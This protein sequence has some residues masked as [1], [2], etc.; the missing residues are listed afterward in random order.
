MPLQQQAEERVYEVHRRIRDEVLFDVL[1]EIPEPADGFVDVLIRNRQ[2]GKSHWI[3]LSGLV[4][5]YER[6]E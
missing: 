3:K 6:V 2:T 4:K 5:K 1:T